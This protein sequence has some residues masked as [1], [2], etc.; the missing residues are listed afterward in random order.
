MDVRLWTATELADFLYA[1][2]HVDQGGV[3]DPP[4]S[5]TWAAV[6]D[7]LTHNEPL[8]AEVWA[9]W[10]AWLQGMNEDVLGARTWLDRQLA[11]RSPDGWRQ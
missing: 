6:V 1:A 8:R 5:T 10:H 11:E 3:I 9:T 7:L 2:Y 4:D